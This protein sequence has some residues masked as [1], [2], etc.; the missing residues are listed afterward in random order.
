MEPPSFEIIQDIVKKVQMHMYKDH[1]TTCA[2]CDER[3]PSF[4]LRSD[5]AART[6]KLYGRMRH[7]IIPIEDMMDRRYDNYWECLR[8]PQDRQRDQRAK[9]EDRINHLQTDINNMKTELQTLVTRKDE[10][11]RQHQAAADEES[12]SRELP[13]L[14]NDIHKKTDKLERR[15][16]EMDKHRLT[17]KAGMYGGD[18]LHPA[19]LAQYDLTQQSTV[20]L[21]SISDR[22]VVDR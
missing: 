11:S 9:Y 22:R 20:D 18:P 5:Y 8:P 6:S 15:I 21:S 14:E 4:A 3:T 1:W 2:V 10:L 12:N 16:A 13:D 17:E 19:L 7:H